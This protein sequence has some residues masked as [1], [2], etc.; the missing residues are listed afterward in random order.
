M[1]TAVGLGTKGMPSDDRRQEILAAALREFADRGFGATSMASIAARAGISKALV[2][3]HFTSKEQ[4][5][6]DCLADIGEPL[7]TRMDQEMG[8]D[9]EPFTM[10]GKALHG[11]FET[12]GPDRCAWRVI[13]D[14]SAPDT[15][16]SGEL[17]SAYRDRIATHATAG[18]GRFLHALGDTD[19][20]DIDALS[21]I[22]TATVD[23]IMAWA[24]EHPEESAEDLTR[25][26]T[27]LIDSVFS[28]GSTR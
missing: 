13:H 18:V 21:R 1:S 3:Q 16:P 22:W 26:F 15:G 28:I 17:T 4:L 27:R 10:P 2:Y 11:I 23:A 9:A 12:L 5:H 14:P 25:R 6:A 20:H 7:L 8:S 24:R 19:E